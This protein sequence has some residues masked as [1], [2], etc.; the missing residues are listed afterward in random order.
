[1]AGK[2]L[3]KPYKLSRFFETDMHDLEQ[4]VIFKE[5]CLVMGYLTIALFVDVVFDLYKAELEKMHG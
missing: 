4:P 3:F 1:M 2:I 5:N